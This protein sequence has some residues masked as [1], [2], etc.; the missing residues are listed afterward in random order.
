[1]GHRAHTGRVDGLELV[2]E[3]YDARKLGRYIGDL[4]R[5][6]FEASQPAKAV[7]VVGAEHSVSRVDFRW[8]LRA[9]MHVSLDYTLRL[10]IVLPVV[11]V[12]V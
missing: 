7:D 5:G 2:H 4:G 6:D 12:L 10:W 9:V 8:P 1:V 3:G 11:K